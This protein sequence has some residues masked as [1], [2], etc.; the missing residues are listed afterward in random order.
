MFS[1]PLKSLT[2]VR[3]S[4]RLLGRSYGYLGKMGWFRSVV[5]T[6]SVNDRGEPIP[7][8]T[9]PSIQFIE[10][11]LRPDMSVFEYG[12]GFSTRWWAKRVQR[13]VSCEHDREWYERTRADVPANVQ[14]IHATREQHEY[15]NQILH[16]TNE[17]DV[18]VIDGRDRVL[19]ARNSVAALKSTGV[20][21]WDNA[22]RAEYQPG[23]QSLHEQGF[24][25]VDFWGLSPMVIWENMTSLFYRDGNC[26]GL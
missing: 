24:R 23:C 21:L 9:Y 5:E 8:I 7:W 6:A 16:Y 10:P 14:M 3:E 19:C 11:R 12:S 26:M 13:V 17:F 2:A 4:T 1:K 20:I 25:R 22:E 18:I 15:S